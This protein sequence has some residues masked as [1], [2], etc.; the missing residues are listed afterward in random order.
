MVKRVDWTSVHRWRSSPTSHSLQSSSSARQI[1]V[2]QGSF[3]SVG[4][5]NQ[6]QGLLRSP[7]LHLGAAPSV[8]RTLFGR[9]RIIAL[10]IPR[11]E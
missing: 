3:G 1:S 10:G 4:S 2:F 9:V 5:L 7:A 11:T 6:I 8:K